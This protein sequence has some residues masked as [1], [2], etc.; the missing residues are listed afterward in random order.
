M[1]NLTEIYRSIEAETDACIESKIKTIRLRPRR[2]YRPE[3]YQAALQKYNAE[4]QEAQAGE[5]MVSA[6]IDDATKTQLSAQKDTS[7]R[8]I[9]IVVAA[10]AIIYLLFF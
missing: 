10:L 4:L 1:R 3:C 9:L 2:A 6:F 5:F 7:L 8:N